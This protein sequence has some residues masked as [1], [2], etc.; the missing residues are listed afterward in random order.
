MK[1][2]AI[3]VSVERKDGIALVRYDRGARANAMSFAIMD[4]LA[5]TAL[6]FVDDIALRCVVLTGTPKVFSAGMDLSDPVFDQLDQMPLEQ[7]RFFSERGA[8]L[9]RAW[10]AIEVPVICAVE[11]PCLAGG[12]ALASM[13][14]FRIASSSAL[15]GAPE[16]QVAH[17]MGWHSVPRLI[18]L[19]GVQATRRILLAGETWA[20]D[21]ARRLGF[22]DE[23]CAAGQ[24]VT[25]AMTM[26]ER[27]ASYP[28]LA[29][30]MIKRQIDASAHA[31]DYATSAYDKDQQ[32]VAW[33]SDD[34]RAARQKFKK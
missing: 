15:F 9:A 10:T 21:E 20:A 24:A 23:T 1:P 2:D 22:V 3:T 34:F 27:I 32:L 12:L 29:V 5:E 7:K 17:N 30:R 4:E 11:G 13:A 8:R 31:L 14:D 6:G 16:V 26:A 18:A 28:G 19:V 33:M 25:C